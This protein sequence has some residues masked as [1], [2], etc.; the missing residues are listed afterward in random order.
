MKVLTGVVAAVLLVASVATAQTTTPT[1]AGAAPAP[2]AAASR[3][4]AVP[5]AE[6]PTIPDGATASS[7]AMAAANQE[8]LA[9]S[10]AIIT[11]LECRKTEYDE[12]QAT[13]AA[14]AN[15]YR[16]GKA[17]LDANNATWTTESA[18][19][20]ARPRSRCNAPAQ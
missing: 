17:R 14:R 3:C 19:Y 12:L 4:P 15:D 13:V 18:E 5:T 10:N 8:Y 7:E 11:V 2:A 1:P 9:W 20:C 16:A 6:P